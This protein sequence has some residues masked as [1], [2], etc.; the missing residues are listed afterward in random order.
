MLVS[1]AAYV[2]NRY[3]GLQPHHVFFL[4][5]M[6]TGRR[7]R[8]RYGFGG[9]GFGGGYGGFG[10]GF[11]RGYGRNRFRPGNMWR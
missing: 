2:G 9:I 10:R 6:L 5:N 11:G 1:A 4:A 7:M 3:F 8:P